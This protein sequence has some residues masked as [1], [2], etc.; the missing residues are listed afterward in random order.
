MEYRRY[1]C[2]NDHWES[3][4]ADGGVMDSWQDALRK[5]WTAVRIPHNWEDY[6]GYHR[7][8][9]GNLHGSAWYRRELDFDPQWRGKRISLL[10]EGVGSY[11]EVW[12]NRHLVGG[13]KGGRTCFR[14]DITP[15]LQEGRNLL[16]VRAW[17]PEKIMDLP[18]VCGGCF[19]T[20]N[21]EGSQP[22]GIFRPV[23]LL[24]PAILT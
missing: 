7:V 16:R 17:H 15:F 19:G 21:T 3:V 24:D 5:A 9:H 8:S 23:S 20:P 10:F 1:I 18:W 4:L 2:L 22:L 13:H 12:V 14:L 6:H 11:A